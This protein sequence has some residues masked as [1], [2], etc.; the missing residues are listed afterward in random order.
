MG[1]WAA[2]VRLALWV[3]TIGMHTVI[4]KFPPRVPRHALVP[5]I[6]PNFECSIMNIDELVKRVCILVM[7]IDELDKIMVML[8][9]DHLG[10][11]FGRQSQ[12]DWV[13]RKLGCCS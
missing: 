4:L 2:A 5:K 1:S 13:C 3:E 9:R 10:W 8:L 6:R 12:D 7:E 11:C